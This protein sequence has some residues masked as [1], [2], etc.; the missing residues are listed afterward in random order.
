MPSSLPISTPRRRCPRCVRRF[1]PLSALLL[2]VGLAGSWPLAQEPPQATST[3]EGAT[4][5]QA[6]PRVSTLQSAEG[7]PPVG[8][9]V[10]DPALKTVYDTM[11]TASWNPEERLITGTETLSWRNTSSVPVHNLCFH[12]YLN[13]FSSNRTTFMRE[14][15]GQLRGDRFDDKRWGWIETTSVDLVGRG[16]DGGALDLKPVEQYIS[17]DDGNPWDRTVAVYPLAEPILPGQVITVDIGFESKMP[18]IFARTGAEGDYI[19]AGQWFPKIGVFE[20]RGDRG[21]AEPGWNC[22]QFHANS[23][24]FADFGNYSVTLTLPERY[25]GKVGATGVQ[26]GEPEIADGQVTVRFAQV[27]VH[28]FAWTGD[29]SFQVIEETFDPSRDV[30]P[31]MRRGVADTLGLSE[32]DLALKPVEITLLLQ[33]D[34]ANQAER[35]LRAAEAGIRGYGLRLGLYPYKTLTM[36]DPPRDGEGSG[37][38]EYP[39]FITLGTRSL[40]AYPPFDRLLMPEVVT[41]HEF[42]HQYF[43]GM[44]ASNEFEESWLDEGINSYYEMVVMEEEYPA[45]LGFLGLDISSFEL[46]RAR[47]GSWRFTDPVD[48]PAWRYLTRSS[49][50]LNSYPRTALTLRHLENLLGAETFH[51]AMRRFFQDHKL[52]HPTTADFERSIEESTGQDLRWFFDQALHSTRQLD[53]AVYSIESRRVRDE[54]GVFWREGERVEEG[55]DKDEGPL[56]QFL[57]GF[58]EGRGDSADDGEQGDEDREDTTWENRV[59]VIRRGDFVHPVTVEMRFE[60]HGV[61]RRTWDGESRWVR[62][63]FTTDRRLVSA[64]VDPDGILA[65]DRNRLDNSERR[66]PDRWPRRKLATELLFWLQSLFAAGGWLA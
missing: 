55:E 52:T 13:A 27:G 47:L 41:V 58:R 38:M 50:G 23:E 29:P 4:S 60:D 53:Y 11:L 64:E 48:L 56:A 2:G 1:A 33:P 32:E 5:Q 34:H 66:R 54:R 57:K 25:A 6:V 49:Y 44:I 26:L 20:D 65:L 28:D 63:T 45:T 17:P 9:S 43:Q 12:H 40:L 31:A 19:L 3:S 46:D 24:F 37:G 62:W 61:L 36:V 10:R 18:A 39:T 21:R 22:H 15:G 42:G 8:W 59:A 30:P 51:R 35:Y 14:S 7:T 16:P